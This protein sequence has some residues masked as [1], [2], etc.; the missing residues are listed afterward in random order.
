L[1]DKALLSNLQQAL[2]AFTAI[3]D[4]F[5]DL[6][7]PDPAEY[8]LEMQ[9]DRERFIDSWSKSAEACDALAKNI[10]RHLASERNAHEATLLRKLLR[11]TEKRRELA[12]DTRVLWQRTENWREGGRLNVVEIA[13]TLF[14]GTTQKERWAVSENRELASVSKQCERVF[15]RLARE[16]ELLRI[17]LDA[18][19]GTKA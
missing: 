14:G 7:F 6:R 10:V 1:L 15:R 9:H 11:H 13:W 18:A 5:E 17:E 16:H 12:E 2:S 19:R 8:V 4:A 3:A